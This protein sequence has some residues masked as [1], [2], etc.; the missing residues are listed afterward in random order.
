[1]TESTRV[2]LLMTACIILLIITIRSMHKT[3]AEA[4]EIPQGYIAIEEHNRQI[5]K[6]MEMN[7][8]QAEKDRQTILNLKRRLEK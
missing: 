3:E 4:V 1:M 7:T 2:R 5:N 8:Y 6:L